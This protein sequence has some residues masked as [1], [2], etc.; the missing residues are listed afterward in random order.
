M[1]NAQPTR[2]IL[3]LHLYRATYL[4]SI[5]KLRASNKIRNLGQRIRFTVVLSRFVNA[6]VLIINIFHYSL[7]KLS[8]RTYLNC[9]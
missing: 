7:I 6:V 8:F 9:G 1:N 3:I 2:L 5:K 4:P